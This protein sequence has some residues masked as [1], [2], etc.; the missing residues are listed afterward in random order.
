[1]SWL[2]SI[3]SAATF[4]I[5]GGLRIPRTD[6]KFPL[7]KW[8]FAVWFATLSCILKGWSLNFWVVS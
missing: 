3:I 7:C 1:M 6:K 4:R 2:Y 8:W 5:D